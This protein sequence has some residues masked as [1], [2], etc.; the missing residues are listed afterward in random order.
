ETFTPPAGAEKMEIDRQPDQNRLARQ[1]RYSA[2]ADATRRRSVRKARPSP[3]PAPAGGELFRPLT[4]QNQLAP[5]LMPQIIRRQVQPMIR[6]QV[7]P[8][9][10]QVQPMI[11]R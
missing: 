1:K 7:Q 5:Q 6:R 3:Y 11:R 8:M 9:I 4:N 2:S 10:R